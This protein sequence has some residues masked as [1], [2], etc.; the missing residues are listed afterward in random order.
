MPDP[1]FEFRCVR[2]GYGLRGIAVDLNCPE[3]GTPILVSVQTPSRPTPGL[4]IASLILGIFGVL[5]CTAYG[6][7]ALV[8]G[9]AAVVCAR[10]A[11][12]GGAPASGV[13]SAGEV[14]GWLGVVL[15]LVGVIVIV[16]L[17]TRAITIP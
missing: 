14:L 3:C 8:F 7:P 11:R 2:C 1:T 12:R 6:V 16:L 4:A 15:G 17:W 13:G 10:L 5:G 9:A